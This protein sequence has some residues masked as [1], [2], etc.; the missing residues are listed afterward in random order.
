MLARC[1]YRVGG[2]FLLLALAVSAAP[3]LTKRQKQ[4]RGLVKSSD[5]VVLGVSHAA[6]PIINLEKYQVERAE[7]ET[8]DPRRRSKYTKGTLYKLAVKEVLYQKPSKDPDKPRRAFVAD[9][10]LMV[11]VPGPAAHP[12]EY[13]KAAFLPSG[14]YLIF[15][16]KTDLDPGDFPNGVR[17]DKNAPM[18]QWD[19]FP[20]PAETY[21]RVLND[22]LIDEPLA[23]KLI[24][25]M[26][27]KLVEDVRAAV[28]ELK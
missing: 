2:F 14:E 26:W 28:R 8:N 1:C 23:A 12:L 7:R 27:P 22:P 21:F 4:L 19:L 11:Y 10:W 16:K 6:D 24:D 9:D 25:E 15:L 18:A 17:Q 13:D 3:Q 5:L 20:N